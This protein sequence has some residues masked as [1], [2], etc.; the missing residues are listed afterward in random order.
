MPLALKKKYSHL[1]YP[2]RVATGDKKAIDKRW[3][4]PPDDEEAQW[5]RVQ[6]WVEDG[7]NWALCPKPGIVCIDV[8]LY[9]LKPAQQKRVRKFLDKYFT[10]PLLVTQTPSGG[11]HFWFNLDADRYPRTIDIDVHGNKAADVI[12]PGKHYALMPG[13]T[14]S[15]G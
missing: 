5:L 12:A 14:L 3:Q 9:K 10:D 7:G 15:D 6:E 8:D 11:L 2:I 4:E 1:G 13:S